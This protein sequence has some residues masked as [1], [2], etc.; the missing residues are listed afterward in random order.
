M[1][2]TPGPGPGVYYR[3]H[4]EAPLVKL[5]SSPRWPADLH[6]AICKIDGSR[7]GYVERYDAEGRRIE[8]WPKVKAPRRKRLVTE[9]KR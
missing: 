8:R 4:R 5:A 7:G 2:P 9:V 1:K 6:D 3:H